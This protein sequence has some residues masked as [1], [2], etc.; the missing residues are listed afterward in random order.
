MQF[1]YTLNIHYY[2]QYFHLLLRSVHKSGLENTL[3]SYTRQSA[4]CFVVPLLYDYIHFN[5]NNVQIHFITATPT[6][7]LSFRPGSD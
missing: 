7:H 4:Q 5:L 3:I 6:I 1:K 2:L